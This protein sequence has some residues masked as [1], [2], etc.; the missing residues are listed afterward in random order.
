M[1]EEQQGCNHD[2]EHCSSKTETCEADLR[3]AEEQKL[4][5]HK[6]VVLSGKGG[7]GKSTMAVNL[8]YGLAARGFKVGLVDVDL[9][10]PSIPTML[11]IKDSTVYARD[12]RLLPVECEGIDVMSVE[13]FL[14]DKDAAV[15]WRG[16]MKY[17][18]IKQFLQETYWGELDYLVVDCPPGTGDEPL[19]V[20]QM[21]T[22]DLLD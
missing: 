22:D 18:A 1:S 13:F 12:E 2:C 4:I 17:G 16:P 11:G 7:V 3:F 20:C 9:H 8:A 21:R 6:I 10:G 5:K 19:G 14:P 15:V